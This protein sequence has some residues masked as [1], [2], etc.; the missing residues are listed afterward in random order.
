MLVQNTQH[1]TN[2]DKIALEAL[3]NTAVS[4]SS[5][6]NLKDVL[7]NLGKQINRLV[8]CD[9]WSISEYRLEIDSVVTVVEIG[10]P[11][12]LYDGDGEE[13]FSLAEN[14]TTGRVVKNR[15][16]VNYAAGDPDISD[17]EKQFVEDYGHSSLL[18]MPMIYRDEVLGIIEFANYGD[19]IR[20]S[21]FEIKI[22]QTLANQ[23]AIALAHAR[24]FKE[25]AEQLRQMELLKKQA[26]EA[27]KA[28]SRFLANMSHELRTPLNAIIGFAEY[29]IE[30]D[31]EGRENLDERLDSLKSIQRSGRHLLKIVNDILDVS[32]V[33]S[34]RIEIY[35]DIFSVD[36]LI[37]ELVE[38]LDIL[39]DRSGN[40]FVQNIPIELGMMY[41]DRQK[42]VQILTNLIGNALKFTDNGE[43]KLSVLTPQSD[44]SVIQFIIED[45]GI[46]IAEDKLSQLFKPFS[47]LKDDYA[48]PAEGTGLGLNLA[49]LYAQALGGNITVN[50]DF[51]IGS[52]FVL[53]LPRFIRNKP[54]VP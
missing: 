1:Q 32:R 16:I 18:M 47:Q 21:P 36:D 10:P 15:E 38:I 43:V 29:L 33:E 11:E 8:R 25:Q 19:S 53:T 50:S 39:A 3:Q 14:E 48:R 28:K 52:R 34:G 12:W 7:N 46:G 44:S 49:K 5:D 9:A 23:G 2:K 6:S 27:N 24:M 20:F 37:F 30:I 35:D 40:T 4:I 41:S 17:D 26:D 51:G 13:I 42:V 45:N 31:E 22:C 54:T